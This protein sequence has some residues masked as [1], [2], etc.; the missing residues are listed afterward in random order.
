MTKDNTY[1][2]FHDKF[3]FKKGFAKPKLAIHCGCLSHAAGRLICM[4]S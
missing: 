2:D 1:I 3:I 4:G